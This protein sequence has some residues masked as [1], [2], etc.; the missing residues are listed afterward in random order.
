MKKILLAAALLVGVSFTTFAQSTGSAN[1]FS[2]GLEGGAPIGDAADFYNAVIGGSIKFEHPIAT[3]TAFTLS[4]GYSAY[5]G[6]TVA[7]IKNP[8]YTA[9]P[10]KAGI[11]YHFTEGFY[12]EGQ[13][14]AAIGTKSGSKVA[15]A[16]APGIG[17][18]FGGGVDIGLRYEG[19]AIKTNNGL[20]NSNSVTLS[21]IA[22]RL[23][24][25][26]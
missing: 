7:G 18:D 25:S 26:F 13:L 17:Y 14:G 16:Y 8:S 3:S 6:K 23:A 19:W 2:I 4:A 24:F 21:Q 1:R 11:K 10:I 5:L 20:G 22:A 12:G 9:I 15:F